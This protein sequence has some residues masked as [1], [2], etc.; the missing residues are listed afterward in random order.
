MKDLITGT[1]ETERIEKLC[2]EMYAQKPERLNYYG[3]E[4]F[5]IKG[6]EFFGKTLVEF[7]NEKEI[8]CNCTKPCKGCGYYYLS[9]KG[10]ALKPTDTP[11][12]GVW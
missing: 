11:L 6:A 7:F 9:D 2:A 12:C 4:D 8:S 10:E 5:Q 1:T 3:Y